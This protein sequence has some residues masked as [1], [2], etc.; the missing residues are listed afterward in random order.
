MLFNVNIFCS[1]LYIHISIY[2]S[3]TGGKLK[4]LRLK[5]LRL[6]KKEAF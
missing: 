1:L 5:V 2:Y 3:H 6:D 4:M